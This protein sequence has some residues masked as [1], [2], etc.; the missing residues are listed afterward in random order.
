MIGNGQVR[1]GGGRRKRG[2]DGYRADRPPYER[3]VNIMPSP[4]Q[5]VE[6]LDRRDRVDRLT[7]GRK[8]AWEDA[9]GPSKTR[10]E[11]GANQATA[12]QDPHGTA[13]AKLLQA[14]S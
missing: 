4:I 12:P 5:W 14:Q 3:R 2:Q 1:F 10:W 7:G 11:A 9:T 6:S 13:K 8:A